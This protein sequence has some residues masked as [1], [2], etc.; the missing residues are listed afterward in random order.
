MSRKI[1]DRIANTMYAQAREY[2]PNIGRFASEDI[3]K[4]IHSK[5]FTLNHYTYAFNQPLNLVDLDGNWPQWAKDTGNWI[6]D[7]SAN[8]WNWTA[9][10]V[11]RVDWVG[12]GGKT[13]WEI[14][15]LTTVP[16]WT[17]RGLS[18]IGE[19]TYND[20]I[21]KVFNSTI[22]NYKGQ[23]VFRVPIGTGGMS[24]GPIMLLGDKLNLNTPEEA[25]YSINT[26]NHEHGHHLEYQQLGLF[27]YLIGI[28]IPSYTNSR[29]D[30]QERPLYF[31]QAWETHADIIAGVFDRGY[32]DHTVETIALGFAYFQHLESS[33]TFKFLSSM[34]INLWNFTNH[35]LSAL[36]EGGA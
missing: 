34:A 20:D 22:S 9:D 8:T 26:L 18:K 7:A 35:D 17:Y 25:K 19:W 28:G 14:S 15:P 33:N 23:I 5:P 1:K 16:T 32:P 24:V 21:E 10:K 13:I 36:K 6:N 4:G 27:K 31:T 12:L 2:M 3:V 11:S 29:R 30:P